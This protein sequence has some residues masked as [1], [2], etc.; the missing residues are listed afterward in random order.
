MKNKIKNLTMNETN[1][2]AFVLVFNPYVENNP[3]LTDDERLQVLLFSFSLC[4]CVRLS[5]CIVAARGAVR[6]HQDRRL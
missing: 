5:V 6:Q 2:E 3:E 1:D 4:L